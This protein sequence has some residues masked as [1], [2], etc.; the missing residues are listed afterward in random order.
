[1]RDKIKIF[2]ILTILLL[3][4]Y[5]FYNYLRES[6]LREVEYVNKNFNIIN[7]IVTRKSVQKGN[8]IWVKYKVNGNVYV[9]S[10]GFL[11][12]QKV[13]VGD[14]V[15]VKYSIDKPELMITEFNDYF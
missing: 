7:G 1:M 12:S 2:G 14:S 6:R 8:H 13:N 9:E 4:I 5:L 3:C 11:E 15:K 10:D